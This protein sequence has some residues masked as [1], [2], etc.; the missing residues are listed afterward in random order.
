MLPLP[1]SRVL[2]FSIDFVV[3][4]RVRESVRPFE[5]STEIFDLMAMSMA[6]FHSQPIKS[7]HHL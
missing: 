1:P 6:D 7:V 4:F 3:L 2:I 5:L